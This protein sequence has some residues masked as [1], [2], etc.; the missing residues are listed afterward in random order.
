M[1]RYYIVLLLV[2]S[3]VGCQD[4]AAR[5]L[6][7]EQARRAAAASKLKQLGQEMH[8]KQAQDATSTSAAAE[9]QKKAD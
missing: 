9:G 1:H 8:A 3:L 2:I 7:A 5:Q 6:R 4:A